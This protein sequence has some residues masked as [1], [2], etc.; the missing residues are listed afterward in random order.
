MLIEQVFIIKSLPFKYGIKNIL[1]FSRRLQQSINICQMVISKLLQKQHIGISFSNILQWVIRSIE[2]GRSCQLLEAIKRLTTSSF[3]DRYSCFHC[4]GVF[5]IS[6]RSLLSPL[7]SCCY[8][9]HIPL[10]MTGYQIKYEMNWYSW[11]LLMLLWLW[12]PQVRYQ[13]HLYDF[14]SVKRKFHIFHLAVQNIALG[15]CILVDHLCE[16]FGLLAKHTKGQSI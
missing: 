5:L 13:L 3:L 16:H 8:D 4:S 6:F 10:M 15:L 2:E 11:A 1:R 12:C 7:Y 14:V 9:S